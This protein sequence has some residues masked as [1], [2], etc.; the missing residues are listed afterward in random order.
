[1]SDLF[2]Y[3]FTQTYR[4]PVRKLRK[5]LEGGANENTQIKFEM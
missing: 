3:L 5:I 2:N 1:M 4:N